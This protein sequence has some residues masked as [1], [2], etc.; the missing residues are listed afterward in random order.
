MINSYL[1]RAVAVA[2]LAGV[3]AGAN[4]QTTTDLGT[5]STSVPTTFTGTVLG[6]AVSFSDIFTFT[7]SEPNISSGYSVLNFPLDL[8]AAG[9][10]GTVL[11]SMS[12]ISYGADGMQGTID[13]QVLSSVVLPSA[14]NSQEQL[15]LSWDG[16][17]SGGHYLSVSG[18]T[19]GSLGGIYTGSI[20]AV[21][22]EPETYAM[23]LAGL[24]LMGAVVRRRSRKTS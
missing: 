21:V 4:A 20:A 23:L 13:D 18:V 24:G 12:L 7:L 5:V 2:V 22:P 9:T 8:G 17:L 15:S 16:A 14:G 6:D 11:S 10:L 19:S 1:K 3:G